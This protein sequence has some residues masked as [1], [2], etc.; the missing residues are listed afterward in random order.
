MPEQT[1]ASPVFVS[2]VIRS[3]TTWLGR[4]LA[5]CR[6]TVY[7]HEPFNPHSP[8]NAALPVPNQ[9]LYLDEY[10]GELYRDLLRALVSLEPVFRGERWMAEIVADRREE[11]RRM[12]EQQDPEFTVTPIIKD[13]T[14][15]YSSEWL[16]QCCGARPVFILRHPVTIVQS[17]VN[18]GWAEN[19]VF[20][21][22]RQQARLVRR[23]YADTP[24]AAELAALPDPTLVP[25]HRAAKFVRFVYFALW[26]LQRDHPDWLFIKYED[27]VRDTEQTLTPLLDALQLAPTERT[28]ELISTGA[29]YTPGAQDQNTL[30]PISLEQRQSAFRDLECQDWKSIHDKYFGDLF[31]ERWAIAEY[32]SAPIKR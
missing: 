6:N 10:N 17:L 31:G 8:W 13:P 15:L 4:L 20:G 7:F 32:A 11:L 12:L 29:S 18:L 30:A 1:P 2:G 21:H 24:V 16:V 25:L 14:A 9:Y 27:L 5:S 3:G 19:I 23:F 22:I 28:L 26:R